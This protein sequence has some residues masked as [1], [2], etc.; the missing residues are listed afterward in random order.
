MD[1]FGRGHGMVRA[2]RGVKGLAMNGLAKQPDR[3]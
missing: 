3:P 2:V 1:D